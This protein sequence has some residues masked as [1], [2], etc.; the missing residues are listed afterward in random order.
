MKKQHIYLPLAVLALTLTACSTP[1]KDSADLKAGID[2]SRTGHYGQAML[3]EELSE[4]DLDV[5]NRILGHLEK[6]HYWNINE[7]QKG[8]D[9]ASSA[10]HHRLASEKELCQW[11][12]EVHAS[13]HHQGEPVHHSA[14]YF[15][16]GSAVPFKTDD[17]GIGHIGHYLHNHPDAKAS[18][19]ASAD[20]VGKS[21]SNQTLSQ[22]RADAVVQLLIKH[23]ASASQLDAK[24]TGEAQ[25]PDNTPDQHHRI[26]TIT[27]AH[28]GYKDCA[29]LN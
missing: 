22:K 14:A 19:T 4:Q 1:R 2:A 29:N 5:A 28:P 26:A 9:A 17:E 10:A 21:A 8:L 11:L 7:K 18:V 16:T 27:T 6:N 12:T 23:G 24:A 20:T 3:H 15:K 13:N 25:G